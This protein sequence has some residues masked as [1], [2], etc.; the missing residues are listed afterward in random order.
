MKD[1]KNPLGLVNKL[2]TIDEFGF[3][4]RKKFGAENY[5][6]DIM[7]GELFLAK[8]PTYSCKI[9][10]PKNYINKKNCGCC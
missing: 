1:D 8:Y 7:L 6:S 3:E 4:I 5:I 10:K 9:I 2:Y